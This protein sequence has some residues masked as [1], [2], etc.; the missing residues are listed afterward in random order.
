MR[1]HFPLVLGSKP[2][3]DEMKF[4]G[5]TSSLVTRPCQIWC[6]KSSDRSVCALFVLDKLSLKIFGLDPLLPSH[7]SQRIISSVISR[8]K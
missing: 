5:R 1:R 6:C 4:S 8:Y 3:D 7:A 2:K